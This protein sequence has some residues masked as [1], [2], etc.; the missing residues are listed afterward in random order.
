MPDR[1]TGRK[2]CAGSNRHSPWHQP[3]PRRS[4]GTTATLSR[5]RPFTDA[6]MSVGSGLRFSDRMRGSVRSLTAASTMWPMELIQFRT[7][8]AHSI[9]SRHQ[10][11][12]FNDSVDG[13]MS[14]FLVA[15]LALR[16]IAFARRPARRRRTAASTESIARADLHAAHG[17]AVEQQRPLLIIVGATWCGPWRTRGRDLSTH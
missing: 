11:G 8:T 2:P 13:D 17:F 16:S 9:S 5:L 14:L 6:A 3:R 12:F 4:A 15:V 10:Q 7:A 1:K